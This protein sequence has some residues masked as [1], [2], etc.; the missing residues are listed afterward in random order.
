MAQMA[1]HPV[2][3]MELSENCVC[4]QHLVG[5]GEVRICLIDMGPSRGLVSIIIEHCGEFRDWRLVEEIND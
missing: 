2:L 4:S 3:N 1:Q 5:V